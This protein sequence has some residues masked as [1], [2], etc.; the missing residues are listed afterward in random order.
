MNSRIAQR[1]IFYRGND[2]DGGNFCFR[3]KMLDSKCYDEASILDK[4]FFFFFV[5][6]L[7]NKYSCQ[8]LS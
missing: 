8:S 1:R 6:F 7:S 2:G 5:K 3:A 4:F